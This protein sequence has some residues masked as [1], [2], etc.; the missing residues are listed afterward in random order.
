MPSKRAFSIQDGN[1]FDVLLLLGVRLLSV[2]LINRHLQL[3]ELLL[4]LLKLINYWFRHFSL[5]LEDDIL[6]S[7]LKLVSLL[8]LLF[9][10]SFTGGERV[11][12]T[13]YDGLWDV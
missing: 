8:L 11:L 2:R 4:E 10:L 12:A 7:L 9:K 5:I 6:N 3:L 13:Q 1:I